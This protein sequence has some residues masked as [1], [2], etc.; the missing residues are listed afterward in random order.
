MRSTEYHL[1]P[2]GCG[3][4]DPPG[5]LF[6]L[7]DMH[8]LP[9]SDDR[10]SS[11]MPSAISLTIE[12]RGAI[13]ENW[14]LDLGCSASWARCCGSSGSGRRLARGDLRAPTNGHGPQAMP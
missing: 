2:N 6:E 12:D 14:V 11:P 10:M 8:H 3:R 9:S 7:D 1:T 4:I 5:M 13:I